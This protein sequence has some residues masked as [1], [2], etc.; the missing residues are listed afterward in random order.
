MMAGQRAWLDRV[1]EAAHAQGQH[2][3][4]H[5]HRKRCDQ[6]AGDAGDRIADQGDDQDV[7]PRR[8]LRYRVDIGELP[9]GQP[10]LDVDR[11]P[12]HFRNGGIR[13]ADRKQRH[14]RKGQMPAPEADWRLNSCRALPPHGEGDGDADGN[15][16]QQHRGNGS[17]NR[18]IATNTASMT[19]SPTTS[20]RLISGD[21][22]PEHDREQQGRPPRRTRRPG[23][24]ATHRSRRSADTAP[25]A[26]SRSRRE[27]RPGPA[28]AAIAPAMPRK[29]DPNTKVRLTMLGPG[30]K[31]HSAKVSLNSSA[32]IHLC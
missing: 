31:W 14:Q 10:V 4:R 22:H 11:D 5:A 28:N 18:P 27:D 24:A 3:R 21:H 30:R 1:E 23:C 6:R 12:M 29:R 20:R 2:R 17:R 32:V 16:H 25:P 9:V 15:R 8:Q 13:A 26:P 19:T 7:R